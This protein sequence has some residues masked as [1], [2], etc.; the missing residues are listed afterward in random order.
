MIMLFFS[1][2]FGN[3]LLLYCKYQYYDLAADVMAENAHLTYKYLTTV[4]GIMT[5]GFVGGG[6]ETSDRDCFSL[7]P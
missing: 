6:I 3:L 5:D 2:T 4:S 1:A 7:N